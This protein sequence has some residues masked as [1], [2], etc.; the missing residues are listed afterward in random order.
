MDVGG[1]DEGAVDAKGA[2]ALHVDVGGTDEGAVDAKGGLAL[3][4]GSTI[5][6][7]LSVEWGGFGLKNGGRSGLMSFSVTI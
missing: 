7:S 2:L 5:S 3:D 1:T 4:V 6:T